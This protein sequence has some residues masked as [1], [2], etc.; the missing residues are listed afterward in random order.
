MSE[1][2]E[3]Q[4]AVKRALLELRQMRGQL[5]EMKRSQTEPIAI[6]GLGLRLPGGAKDA[7]TYWQ[8]LQ[9]G[10]DAIV[11]IPP[12][13]WDIDAFYDPDPDAPGKMYTRAGGFLD[14]IDQFDPHFFG[15]SPR[16]AD[17][18]DPQQRLLLQVSWEA[19][20]HAGQAPDQ[21]K[22]SQT[23]VFVGLSGSDYLRM[24]TAVPEAIDVYSI[25]GSALSVAAGR[26]S[27]LLGLQGPSLVVDTA[28]SS[29]LVAVHLACQSLR[30]KESSLALA[31]GVGL[32]LSPEANINFSRAQMMA[33]D[34]RCKTFDARADGYVRGEG[35][36]M[37]VLKRLSDALADGNTI[38]ALVRGSAV[39]Q[40][41]RS[42][43]LTAPNGPAQE[44]V[45]R[46]ALASANLQPHQVQYV[47][48]HGTGTSLG[49]PIEVQAL[50]AVLGQNRPAD[51][52]LALGSVKTN[53]GHLEAAAGVAGLIK[54]ALALQHGE[55]PPHLHLQELNPFIN[56]AHM[57]L[58]VPTERIPW[59]TTADRRRAGVSSFGFSGT[60]AHII[61]EQAPEI[62]A[63]DEV[64]IR[65]F[66]PLTLS[67]R[68]EPA[69]RQ[70]AQSYAAFLAG[71]D[72][73]FADIAYTSN[74]GRSHLEKRLAVVAASAP[75]AQEKLYAWAAGDGPTG[76][77][78]GETLPGQSPE[79]AFL[80]TGH[81]AQYPQM[82][83]QL[84]ASSPTFRAAID[85]CAAAAAVYLDQ[86]LTTILFPAT[87]AE[88][89]LMDQMTYAQPAL[90]A[91][92]YALTAVWQSWGVQPTVVLGHSLGEYVA[93]CVAGVFSL[94]D[95]MKLVC[96][97]GRLMDSLPQAGEMAVVFASEVQIAPFLE[98]YADRVAIGVINGPTSLVISGAKTA[99]QTIV[100]TLNQNE[101]KTRAL[102]VAQAA[103]SPLLDPIL[104]EFEAVAQTIT[105]HTPQIALVSCL[106]GQM[107]GSREVTH[108]AY[109]R[110]HLRQ[111]VRF[112]DGMATLYAEGY[113]T[114]LEI[115][116]HPALLSMGQR[117][118]P[119]ELDPSLPPRPGL[120]RPS[121]REGENEWRELLESAAALHVHGVALDWARLAGNG[122]FTIPYRRVPLPTNPWQQARYWLSSQPEAEAI[123][124]NALWQAAAAAGQRQQLHGPL[125]LGMTTYPA[126][127][128]AM[129]DLTV[130]YIVK[131]LRQLGVFTQAGE[132]QTA[133]SIISQTGIL[134]SY[135][136]LLGRWL[137]HLAA[138]G[139][140]VADGE[141]F[142]SEVAL[143][144]RPFPTLLTAAQTTLADVPPLLAYL[145]RCGDW[146]PDILT[147]K[148]SPLE[149]IFPGGS[150]ETA[151][152]LYHH[153]PL[154]QYFNGISAEVM[155]AIAAQVPAN[156][157]LRILEV[158]AGTGGTAAALL[159]VLPAR[160][161][162]YH[163]TDLSDLFLGR[164][165][166]RYAAYPFVTYGIMDIE[167]APEAQGHRPHSF[168]VIV[169]ANVLHATRHLDETLAHVQALLAPGG[170]LLL[171]EVTSHF[172]WFDIT[173]GL[174]EG[175]GLH[176]DAWRQDNPLLS[177]EQWQAALR[178]A[179]FAQ[180]AAFPEANA[181]PVALGSNIIVAQTAVPEHAT[182]AVFGARALP[183]ARTQAENE[184]QTV[185]AETAVTRF[186]DQFQAALPDEQEE[187]LIAFVRAQVG[188]VL[189][190]PA[191]HVIDQRHRLMDLGVDSLMAVELRNRLQTGLD[192]ASTL[193][194]TLIFDYP[195]I[196][197]IVAYLQARLVGGVAVEEATAVR[198]DS[199][200]D[201]ATD[202]QDLSDDE[203][204][205][206]LL[207]KLDNL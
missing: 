134:P 50:A 140:L 156:R 79:V 43:G 113:G 155:Q 200:P 118:W 71:T 73:D 185:V 101:I 59:P 168:D 68:S 103:H 177:P 170:L 132:R 176:E 92:E 129:A 36:A 35:C 5:D 16:E 104:D 139:D 67:A 141:G 45:L 160:Q 61:L 94:A 63:R 186:I 89:A 112:A 105:Y 126:K 49:D 142:V 17:A 75:E 58:V 157:Q 158:G 148:L 130:A 120:W 111:P 57:P 99:V 52:P 188:R 55:I 39:N 110:R 97:R 13:R 21:L 100:A 54:A 123:T 46:R 28:C 203:V 195:T 78:H 33:K 198:D 136:G 173:T 82:G 137:D 40:D 10:V 191:E 187:M 106:T 131:A 69:L 81:G 107:T 102:A 119:P 24:A 151:D 72:E 116:P 162:Q 194:A 115:G 41:G 117:C 164:A 125:S 47:E 108:A 193:P 174:I 20:E 124:P 87:D 31:G 202:L 22:D 207:K 152:Y 96:A 23:G 26:L 64:E 95:G 135:A 182:T 114:F 128:Q 19:L 175:W 44:A 181:L 51:Q 76:V 18:M 62:A 122:R 172:T 91:V 84:Y 80:F 27:Y 11:P 60:N 34:D 161:T 12:N 197:A 192:L 189:R 153:W 204:E 138:Q 32:I 65:P 196:A 205:A 42:S 77:F 2:T 93:A 150:Y 3:P 37:I 121:L 74:D 183:T 98:P 163:F 190:L 83:Q 184:A 146:L 4:S 178:A 199:L 149:T 85:A 8:L 109:W 147:G 201:L 6:V 86:P 29:S 9:N 25:T 143:A 154:V 56:W 167:K 171:F 206:L 145:Q 48:A 144:E 1:A 159:P 15:I 14:A 90:F 7:D 30:S 165:E 70:L 180:T 133:A 38:L 169:A 166:E 88:S 53:F 127:W 179:G 66:H